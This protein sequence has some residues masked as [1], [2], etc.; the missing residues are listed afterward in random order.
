MFRHLDPKTSAERLVAYSR[1]TH[2]SE[3]EWVDTA[4]PK[5]VQS[6]R[7]IT[8]KREQEVAEFDMQCAKKVFEDV[9]DLHVDMRTAILNYLDDN[10]P[11]PMMKQIPSI[12][13]TK[14]LQ[15]L[16]TAV[17]GEDREDEE[18]QREVTQD[19]IFAMVFSSSGKVKANK[20]KGRGELAGLVVRAITT[21]DTARN[22]KQDNS[23]TDGVN[24]EESELQQSRRNCRQRMGRRHEQ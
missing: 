6:A 9:G 3:P 7:D 10:V 1:L 12:S 4:R 24:M 18:M 13:T 14:L 5:T 17:Q 15:S 21:A 20:G 19:G 11:V 16:T 22:D 2:P 8:E 23:W